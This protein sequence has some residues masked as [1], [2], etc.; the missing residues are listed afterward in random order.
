MKDAMD[1][2][3]EYGKIPWA[4]FKSTERYHDTSNVWKDTMVLLLECRKIAWTYFEIT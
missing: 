2:L 4:Y 1:L 3:L